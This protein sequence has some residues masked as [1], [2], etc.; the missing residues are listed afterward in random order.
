MN[1]KP[2]LDDFKL[3]PPTSLRDVV[4]TELENQN[5]DDLQAGK[6]TR[7]LDQISD[8]EIKGLLERIYSHVEKQALSVYHSNEPWALR[9]WTLNNILK[10]E[11][12][13]ETTSAIATHLIEPVLD[14]QKETFDPISY[15]IDK[16]NMERKSQSTKA[17]YLTTAARFVSMLGRKKHYPDEDVEKY[18]SWANKNFPNQNTYHQECQ[19]L[20]R[21]LRTLP[22]GKGRDL[23]INM[24][25]K[26]T[27]C[28]QPTLT[29]EEVEKLVWACVTENVDCN[30]VVRLCVSSI[31]GARIGELAQILSQDICLDGAK[32]TILIKTEKGGQ[33]KPQPIPQSLLP[34][35]NVPIEPMSTWKLQRQFRR[36]CRYLGIKIDPNSKPERRGKRGPKPQ[37]DLIKG[38]GFHSMRRRVV[39][40]ISEVETSE[41]SIHNFVRW[42]VPRQYSMLARYRQTPTEETDL[43]ILEKHP[44]AKLWAEVTPYILEY[45]DSYKNNS[46]YINLY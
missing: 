27:D 26:P 24:P 2:A 5:I 19:K 4:L 42:A 23:P 17:V 45:N 12:I 35:F 30:L 36:L 1:K 7:R 21:F 28:Q 8:E 20:L 34:L 44:I 43:A 22:N 37:P 11:I 31:Y 14:W 40:T 32:S 6:P 46:L 18:L 39:T 25:K 10:D 33:R 13:N 3:Q 41:I 38:F 16:L 29:E 15:Y 9:A